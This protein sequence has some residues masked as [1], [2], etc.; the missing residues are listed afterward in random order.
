MDKRDV[1]EVTSRAMHMLRGEAISWLHALA[2][3]DAL[4]MIEIEL[5]RDFSARKGLLKKYDDALN[6]LM[7]PMPHPTNCRDFHCDK[8]P[9]CYTNYLPH[10]SP[11]MSL[12]QIILF[13]T[14]WTYDDNATTKYH[15][16]LGY[17]YEKPGFYNRQNAS[18]IRIKISSGPIYNVWLCGAV[19]N[20]LKAADFYIDMGTVLYDENNYEPAENSVR[21]KRIKPSNTM[22][23]RDVYDLPKGEHVL[24]I[25]PHVNSSL[26]LTHVIAWL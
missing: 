26:S 8:V 17:L 1:K 11:N 15:K 10:F 13:N 6:A 12:D 20:S 9:V 24:T 21:W 19:K 7:P 3:L 23:C 25:V 14:S 2:F 16:S 5:K 4:Y 18:V 22:N